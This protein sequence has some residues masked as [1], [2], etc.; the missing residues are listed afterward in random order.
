MRNILMTVSFIL[1]SGTAGD[2]RAQGCEDACEQLHLD[3]VSN[4]E[5]IFKDTMI[6]GMDC[7]ATCIPS[8]QACINNCIPLVIDL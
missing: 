7:H 6:E 5:K 1:V 3:C 2:I 4:C 8:R